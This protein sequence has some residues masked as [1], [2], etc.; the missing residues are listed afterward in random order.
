MRERVGRFG[1]RD[2]RV[3][4]ADRAVDAQTGAP[5]DGDVDV[6]PAVVDA[7]PASELVHRSRRRALLARRRSPSRARG[8]L[9]RSRSDPRAPCA[10][11]PPA[12]SSFRRSSARARGAGT[13]ARAG[14]TLRAARGSSRTAR[15]CRTRP[16][17]P[18]PLHSSQPFAREDRAPARSAF[19]VDA[20]AREDPRVDRHVLLAP[21]AE[22]PHQALGQHG[23]DRGRHEERLRRPCR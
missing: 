11:R 7:A 6:A 18:E 17:K 10:R 4:V 1:R 16:R 8:A 9:R 13:S 14:S 5:A 21:R 19:S 15:R 3:E 12:G 22:L 23:A 2:L 20:R